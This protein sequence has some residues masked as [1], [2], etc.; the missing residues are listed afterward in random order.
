MYKFKPGLSPGF[1]MAK[2]SGSWRSAKVHV[3]FRLCPLIT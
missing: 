3:G 2:K 1:F